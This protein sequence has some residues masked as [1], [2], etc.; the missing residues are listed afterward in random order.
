MSVGGVSEGVRSE[1]QD[2]IVF[3]VAMLLLATLLAP[4]LDSSVKY[5]TATL[6]VLMIA[7]GRYLF[8][9]ILLWPIVAV[10]H[11]S[12]LWRMPDAKLQ[13]LRSLVIVISAIFFFS[14]LRTTPLAD[15]VAIFFINPFVVTALAPWVL[16]ER[17]GIWRWGAVVAG[18][19]G[20]LVIIQPG[21]EGFGW[22]TGFALI[23]GFL[24]GC[25]VLLSRKV[26]SGGSPPMVAGLLTG[27]VGA[28]LFG[29]SLPFVWQTPTLWEVSLMALA[30]AFG[31]AV[32][33]LFMVAYINADASRLVPFSYFELLSASLIGFLIFGDVP[34]AITWLG[35]AIIA[36]SGVTIAYRER[37]R[38]T[39]SLTAPPPVKR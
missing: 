2:R 38:A 34:D 25:F 20:V 35:M 18:F 22:G 10:R 6:P 16:G 39:R 9:A 27:L 7:T 37:R 19:V 11:P 12:A 3:A 31:A 21:F 8:Q 23:A 36:A 29:L 17:V 5:L 33:V 30:G 24:F 13:L 15:V 1:P 26:G 14:A 4:L 28:G 32:H